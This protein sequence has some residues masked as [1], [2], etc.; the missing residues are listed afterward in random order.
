MR[1]GGWIAAGGAIVWAAS[2]SPQGGGAPPGDDGGTI[3]PFDAGPPPTPCPDGH[4]PTDPIDYGT[5]EVA[6][7]LADAKS[8][9]VVRVVLAADSLGASAL[10]AGG[11]TLDS[12]PESYA[13][14]AAWGATFVVGREAVGAMYGALDVAE[15]LRDDG[16]SSIPPAAP[17]TA[18]P[19]VALRA[20]N[21]FLVLPA[22]AETASTWWFRDLEFWAEYLDMMAHARLDFLDLHAMYDTETTLFPNAL[23]YFGTS[24]SFPDVGVSP[25]DRAANVAVLNQV[26]AMAAARGIR[27]GVMSY[28]SDTSPRAD[29]TGPNLSDPDLRT[30]TRE[31]AAD[32]V[33]RVPKLARL[34]FRI[35][36]SGHD[37]SW[38]TDTIVKGVAAAATGAG[39]YTRTW[40]TSK[41]DVLALVSSAGAG[42]GTIVE[43]KYNGEHFAAPYAI[44]GAGMSTWADYSYQDYL[45]PPTPYTFVFQIRAG[46]TH[47]MFRFAS[48]ERA[49]RAALSLAMSPRIAGFTFEAAHAYFPQRDFYHAPADVF[50]PWTFRRDELSYAL[51]GRLAYDASTPEP[52][53]RALLAARVGTDGLWDALQASSDVAPWIQTALTCGP[54]QRDYAPEL[55]LDA[56]VGWWAS[57]AGSHADCT[58]HGAFDGFAVAIPAEVADDLAAGRTTTKLSPVT[59]AQFVLGDAQR[60][61]AAAGVA[62]DAGNAE[63]RDVVRDCVAVSDLAG[64]FAHKLRAATALAVYERTA[65]ADFLGVARAEAAL[66]DAAFAQLAKD[67]AYIA[68]FEERMRMQGLGYLPFHWSDEVPRLGDDGAAI[69]AVVQQ[70]TAN[71]PA[72]HGTLPPAQAWL[73][74]ARAAG[75]GLGALV[76]SPPDPTAAAW[77]VAVTLATA[78]PAGAQVRVFWKPYDSETDWRAVDASG[79][80]TN[81]SA[82]VAGGGAGGLFAVE[83]AGPPGQGWRLP[84]VTSETPYRVIAP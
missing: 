49:R 17:S 75:P 42:A 29:G 13:V 48:Y 22:G 15:R 62:V 46:G 64:W 50:S 71:P 77:N 52:R 9:A 36:E 79:S 65:S 58:H 14:V 6:R 8:A 73:D 72:F 2:C 61:G 21:P 27:V 25:A 60:A 40:G 44:A 20:A 55:E 84:D 16:A 18:A 39:V 28:R 35:G 57:P 19:A 32:L 70:V 30:Y 1:V 69:D 34:G 81:W 10:Q 45:E 38:Y 80:G 4:Q 51:M 12:R 43:A 68:P 78:P 63:A 33:T 82:P 31:A 3:P 74:G 83:V 23:L 5:C 7:A 59:V 76:V 47:R 41:P 54:D 26:V 11:V 66:A 37:A 56:D 67:T 53:F 24:A